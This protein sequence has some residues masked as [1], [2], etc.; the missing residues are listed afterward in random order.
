MDS[1]IEEVT[2]KTKTTV[3]A[4]QKGPYKSGEPLM[5]S[6]KF[7]LGITLAKQRSMTCAVSTSKNF[8]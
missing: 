7:S 8:E 6:R 5:M 1:T 4:I 3:V 2:N